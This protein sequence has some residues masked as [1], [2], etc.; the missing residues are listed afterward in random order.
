VDEAAGLHV[1]NSSRL[2]FDSAKEE[3]FNELKVNRGG[4]SRQRKM[5]D[6]SS[7]PVFF[8]TNLNIP[9]AQHIIQKGD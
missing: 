4:Y 7:N 8:E 1:L 6:L 9:K 2:W 3:W 5:V